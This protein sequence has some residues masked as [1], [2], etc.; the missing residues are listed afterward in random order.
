MIAD[1]FH[2]G[3][4]AARDW[5][6]DLHRRLDELGVILRQD[7]PVWRCVAQ[8]RE[9]LACVDPAVPKLADLAELRPAL[10]RFCGVPMP[11]GRHV[12]SICWQVAAEGWRRLYGET[13]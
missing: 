12:E 3:P 5:R 10:E 13:G 6:V 11:D 4:A 7:A 8:L 9:V 2:M 1:T